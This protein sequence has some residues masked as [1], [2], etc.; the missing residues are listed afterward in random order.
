MLENV[1]RQ[2]EERQDRQPA[3]KAAELGDFAGVVTVVDHADDGEQAAGREAVVD[4]LQDAA[5]TD[6]VSRANSPS[7]QKPNG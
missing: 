5:L 1:N 4:H 6:S 7:M 3:A 2:H